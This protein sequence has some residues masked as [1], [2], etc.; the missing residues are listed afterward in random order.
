MTDDTI[1]T[2]KSPRNDG[3]LH[4]PASV[5]PMPRQDPNLP[6]EKAEESEVAG[7]HKNSGQKDHKGAR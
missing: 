5:R 4:K 1:G 6:T 3:T 7:R 2:P